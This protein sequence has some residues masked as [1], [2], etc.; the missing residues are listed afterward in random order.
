MYMFLFHVS[1]AMQQDILAVF[2]CSRYNSLSAAS[3]W[4]C[5]YYCDLLT[6]FLCSSVHPYALSDRRVNTFEYLCLCVPVSETAVGDPQECKEIA[7]SAK[8]TGERAQFDK[9]R[10]AFP[11]KGLACQFA[12]FDSLWHRGMKKNRLYFLSFLLSTAL[13]WGTRWDIDGLRARLSQDSFFENL[14]SA[15]ARWN[16]WRAEIS[17]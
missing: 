9:S 8:G 14:I 13:V 3:P 5:H 7:L 4:F 15:P 12:L 17:I 11:W 2:S 1:N 16:N 10:G 6:F